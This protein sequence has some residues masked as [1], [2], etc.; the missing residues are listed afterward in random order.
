MTQPCPGEAKRDRP[1]DISRDADP[2][3]ILRERHRAGYGI[4]ARTAYRASDDDP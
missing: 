3:T 4:P 1:D 2:L